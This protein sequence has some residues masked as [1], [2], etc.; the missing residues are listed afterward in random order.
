MIGR[1]AYHDPAMLG[2]ADRLLFDAD[3]PEVRPEAAVL[4]YRSYVQGELSRGTPFYAM[5]RHT[6][7]LFHGRPGARA[8]RR[9]LTE[10]GSKSGAGLQVLDKALDQVLGHQARAA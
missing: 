8:W 2:R 4:A 10:E 7:G 5:A 9:V 1:A 6:L 3:A